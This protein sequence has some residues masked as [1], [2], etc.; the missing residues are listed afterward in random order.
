MAEKQSVSEH[1]AAV[2][3]ALNA[4]AATHDEA[5]KARIDE[6]LRHVDTAQAQLSAD[7]GKRA[8]EINE[9]LREIEQHGSQAKTE[10]GDTLRARIQKM[11][12]TCKNAMEKC[13]EEQTMTP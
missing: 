13:I 1:L 9:H 11:I 8:D 5:A 6:A 10:S 3:E 2:H 12:E 7:A 4:A